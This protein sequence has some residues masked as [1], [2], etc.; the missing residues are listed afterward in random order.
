MHK[1]PAPLARLRRAE[2]ILSALGRITVEFKTGDDGAPKRMIALKGPGGQPQKQEKPPGWLSRN[3][4]KV[5]GSAA[6]LTGIAG[7]ATLR[8]RGMKIPFNPHQSLTD[9]LI[10]VKS[11]AAK[12]YEAAQRAIGGKIKKGAAKVESAA[13][14]VAAVHPGSAAKAPSGALAPKVKRTMRDPAVIQRATDKVWSKFRDGTLPAAKVAGAYKR[15][16]GDS[17]MKGANIPAQIATPAGKPLRGRARDMVIG[18][19]KK[20]WGPVAPIPKGQGSL[21]LASAIQRALV[22]LNEAD[23]EQW[24]KF[25]PSMYAGTM[26][27]KGRRALVAVKRSGSIADDA[28][29]TLAGKPR[30]AGKKKE[31]EKSWFKNAVAGAAIGAGLYATPRLYARGVTY[32]TK[33]AVRPGSTWGDLISSV[34]RGEA[35]NLLSAKRRRAPVEFGDW[36]LSD[37]RGNSARVFSPGAKTRD[38]RDKTEWEKVD[39]IRAVRNVAVGAAVGLGG[40]ATVLALKNRKLSKPASVS[41]TGP[42]VPEVIAHDFRKPANG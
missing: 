12:G 20:N 2:V 7:M 1:R 4:W 30:E 39:R 19:L 21:V 35:R 36:R 16:W 42:V 6:M 41:S 13:A 27:R 18:K 14:V 31:W 25:T 26:Y 10:G 32:K 29:D 15:F 23:P 33:G 11:E 9:D 34:H 5:A 40:L 37:A 8:D 22:L 24:N 3:K 17:A 38:R 28:A